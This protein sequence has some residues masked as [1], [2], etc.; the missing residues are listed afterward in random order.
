MT[1]AYPLKSGLYLNITNRCSCACVFCLRNNGANVYN[2]PPLWLDHEPSLDEIKTAIAQYNLSL[3]DETV[4]CG[5]GEPTMRLDAM[6]ATAQHLKTLSPSMS[7]RLN[8]NGLANLVHGTDVTPRFSGLL[9]SVS[10]SLNTSDPAKYLSICR[11]AFGLP[12]HAALLEFATL[13]K[14]HVPDVVFTIVGS[15]VTDSAEQTAC[16]AIAERLGVRLR[17]RK[18][19]STTTSAPPEGR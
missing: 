1:V 14:N 4:F 12:S 2:T 17:I 9:D 8:T 18:Y 19:E 3:F 11:P 16:R 6:L 13:C 10:I 7:I 15:P 5:Y